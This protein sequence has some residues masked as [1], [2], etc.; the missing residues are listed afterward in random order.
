MTNSSRVYLYDTTLRDDA[1]AQ[2]VDFSAADKAKI[3]RE[4]DALERLFGRVPPFK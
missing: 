4:L 1:Q 3:A 2:G